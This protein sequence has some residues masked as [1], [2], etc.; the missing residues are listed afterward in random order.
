MGGGMGVGGA[1]RGLG[2]ATQQQKPQQMVEEEE[3]MAEECLQWTN[4]GQ[5]QRHRVSHQTSCQC[6]QQ[7]QQQYTALCWYCRLAHSIKSLNSKFRS[8]AL[9]S[10]SGSLNRVTIFGQRATYKYTHSA[11]CVSKT[12][13]G[14]LEQRGGSRFSCQWQDYQQHFLKEQ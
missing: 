7:Q 9:S 11:A 3:R 6:Q 8:C 1:G 14:A 13:F 4:H 2:V 5:G 10:H 12:K